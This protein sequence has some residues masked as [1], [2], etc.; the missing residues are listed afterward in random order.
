MSSKQPNAATSLQPPEI[1]LG[2][3]VLVLVSAF[4]GWMFAGMVMVLIPLAGRSAAISFLG[5]GQEAEVGNWFSRYIC[6]FLLGAATG[7]LLFGWLG[8]RVGRAK[9]MGW[10]ILCYSIVTGLTYFVTSP[11]Q[12]LVLRFVACLGVGGMWPNGVSLASEAWSNVSRPVL[13]GLIGTSA[14]LGFMLLS[15][16]AMFKPVTP[17]SWR[18]LMLVC[19]IPVFLGIVVL[20]FVPESPRWLAGQMAKAGDTV[21]KSSSPIAEIFRPP[22]LRYTLIGICLGAIPLLGN[23][24]GSNWL[25]PWAGQVGG[26]SDPAL[27]AWAQWSKSGGAVVGSLLGGWLASRFGRRTT[28]FSISLA[29][30]CTAMYGFWFLSPL[31]RSFLP[32]ACVLGFFATVYFGWLPLYLPELFPTR[33]RS[34]G[35]GVTFNFGRFATAVG[36]LGAGQLM[37]WF[38]GNYAMAGR[39]TCMVYFLGMIIILFAPD[40]SKKQL[41]D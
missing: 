18:W 29:A 23:W 22:L 30:L 21:G 3:Q 17:E 20:V 26:L 16:I 31:D 36:V 1:S 38:D 40:T 32:W 7:G 13:A 34:T 10:S 27:K 8:D 39:I 14:N 35:T 2:G 4:L 33:V 9:A 19:A 41:E 6:A 12:L 5:P 15:T 25:V 11:E 28:Y 37:L 24:G